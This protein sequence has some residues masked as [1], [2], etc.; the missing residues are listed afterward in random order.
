MA[1]HSGAAA[2]GIGGIENAL[3]RG[4]MLAATRR[5]RHHHCGVE[6]DLASLPD[7]PALLQQMLRDAVTTVV[8]STGTACRE[9]QTP[10]LINACCGIG[11]VRVRAV[12]SRSTAV[13]AGGSGANGRCRTDAAKEAAD[14]AA[15]RQRRRGDARPDR[16]HGALP[17]H[18]PR[19]EV[20]IDIEDRACP[21]CGGSLQVMGE[22]R[23]EQLDIAPAQLRVRVT[24]RP[25]YVCNSCDGVPVVA[26]APERPI[27]GGMATEALI[28]HVVVSKFCDGLPLYRQ[29]Q[30]LARQGRDAGP[31]HVEQLGG[32]GL[33]VADAAV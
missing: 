27:D 24:R 28:V 12:G 8:I 32:P 31:I 9:R 16:N 14:I 4:K 22:L 7:D 18:L 2:T 13:R 1:C 15:G 23:T 3:I 26:P 5:R 29:S 21:C 11:L 25:R 20:V 33:L 17:A 6:I 19:Y 10:Q 30:M